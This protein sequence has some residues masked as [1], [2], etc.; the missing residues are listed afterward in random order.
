MDVLVTL[1]G[2]IGSGYSIQ[3]ALSFHDAEVVRQWLV[4]SLH[5]N[6]H[7]FFHRPP[8]AGHFRQVALPPLPP[9]RQ[10]GQAPIGSPYLVDQPPP[11]K[12]KKETP[13][14]TPALTVPDFISSTPLCQPTA[15]LP[16]YANLINLALRATPPGKRMPRLA[17]TTGECL[18]CFRSICPPP[19]NRCRVSTC[20]NASKRRSRV[21]PVLHIDLSCAPWNTKAEEFWQPFVLWLQEPSVA[22]LLKPTPALIALTPATTW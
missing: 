3:P 21:L 10:V 9:N 12:Q 11:K 19:H 18:I 20:G 6:H 5:V 22:L 17:D 16:A 8:P 13:A 7:E 14:L 2:D 1:N 4:R 15:A